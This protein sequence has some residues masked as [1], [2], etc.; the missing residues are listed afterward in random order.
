M[1]AV[2]GL[3]PTSQEVSGS[4]AVSKGCEW[5]W[6][7]SSCGSSLSHHPLCPSVCLPPRQGQLSAPKSPLLWCG[8]IWPEGRRRWRTIGPRQR[9]AAPHIVP[10]CWVEGGQI[11]RRQEQRAQRLR[12]W[13]QDVWKRRCKGA[14]S[15]ERCWMRSP[16]SRPP[17]AKQSTENSV[18]QPFVPADPISNISIPVICRAF[19]SPISSP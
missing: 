5:L 18:P 17:E 8:A 7:F 13:G 10:G 11:A 15:W 9:Q 19:N 1:A 16:G 3:T 14:E 4:P 6:P 12:N 2:A